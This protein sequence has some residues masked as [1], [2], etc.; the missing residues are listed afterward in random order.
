MR[1]FQPRGRRL[2][3]LRL[4]GV[5]GA[6]VATSAG[7]INGDW[8]WAALIALLGIYLGVLTVREW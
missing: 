8:I 5:G 3:Q 6:A 1:Q 7:I 2:R 4:V